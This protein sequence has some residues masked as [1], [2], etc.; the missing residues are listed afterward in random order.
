MEVNRAPNA[1]I[2]DDAYFVPPLAPKPL[3]NKTKATGI[4][5]RLRVG[6]LTKKQRNESTVKDDAEPCLNATQGMLEV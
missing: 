2:D 6:W 5:S 3:A 1:T 4:T